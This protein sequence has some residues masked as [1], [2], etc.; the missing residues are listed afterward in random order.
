MLQSR[1]MDCTKTRTFT[2]V[3]RL[4]TIARPRLKRRG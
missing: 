3:S 1:S 2:S 4:Y